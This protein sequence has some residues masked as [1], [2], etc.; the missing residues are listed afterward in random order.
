MHVSE[1]IEIITHKHY[2]Y[3]S[4]MFKENSVSFHMAQEQQPR[5]FHNLVTLKHMI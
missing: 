3:R 4:Y 2:T 1:Y 5:N